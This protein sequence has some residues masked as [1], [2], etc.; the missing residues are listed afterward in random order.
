MLFGVLEGFYGRPWAPSQR[1][2][3]LK[4][5][6]SLGL[7]AY[8]YAPKDDRKHRKFW[9]DLYSQDELD[10]LGSLVRASK[11]SGIE[12]LYGISPGIDMRFS[13]AD[14]LKFLFA[15]VD[16][17]RSLGVTSIALLFDDIAS[18][19]HPD[20]SSAFSSFAIAQSH[21]ANALY[22]H[23]TQSG[24]HR[25][26]FCPT[27]YC[28]S[29][30]VPNLTE[31]SYLR[32]VGES[33]RP[34]IHV[35]WTGPE[36][37]SN[38]ITRQHIDDVRAVLRRK[39]MIWD[40]L[41][42]NDYDQRR[43]YLGPYSGRNA[44]IIDGI[45]GVLTN[46][47]CEFT[48]NFVPIHTLAAWARDP[49]Q[50]KEDEALHAAITAWVPVFQF[51]PITFNDVQLLVDLMYLP[52]DHGKRAKNALALFQWLCGNTATHVDYTSKLT[53]FKQF[54]D[55][56]MQLFDEK[57]T[58]IEHRDLAYDL[59]AYLWGIKEMAIVL[60]ECCDWLP[61]R[62]SHPNGFQM[63][64]QYKQTWDGGFLAELHRLLPMDRSSGLF[65]PSSLKQN[66][67]FVVRPFAPNDLQSLYRVCLETG[68]SGNDA[69]H[70]YPTYPNAIGERYVGAYTQVAGTSQFVLCDDVGV[71]GYVLAAHDSKAF[72]QTF[73][74]EWLPPVAAK[75][76]KPTGDLS[77][78]SRE[79][80]IVNELY[81]PSEY[82]S[83]DMYSKYPAHLHIDMMA[84]AQGA[85]NG[86]HMIQTMLNHLKARNIPGVYLCMSDTNFRALKFYTK[87][88]FSQIEG[89]PTGQ[90]CLYLGKFL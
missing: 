11:D 88:G 84:R 47:N 86:T 48:L 82:L 45:S 49:H 3:L 31:S 20:D 87:L 64:D 13:S 57:V 34:D 73:F 7:N 30:A 50:Y 5:M 29:R 52:Y 37:V 65:V 62:H 35:L 10:H 9:R 80:E 79:Q 44:G 66:S 58:E 74:N 68:D 1:F 15:K 24:P 55:D 19:M 23:I 18:S 26:L 72:Y 53:E 32:E 77:T 40:N 67:I 90:G 42:A 75:Y 27:E 51:A 78:W 85:G 89:S 60:R 56:V 39:P 22:H 8:F 28:S 36:I 59:Y 4:W 41:H 25:M 46:P 61:S 16:Q 71:C 70:L 63:L 14:D 17:V 81:H 33:L 54:C 69:T 38:E 6:Q 83:D 12:F 21:V 43:A 76:P 2:H